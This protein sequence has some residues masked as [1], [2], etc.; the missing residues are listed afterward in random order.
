[1]KNLIFALLMLA[2]FTSCAKSQDSLFKDWSDVQ[3]FYT[4]G[5]LPPPYHYSYDVAVNRNGV[6]IL[7]YRL[8]YETNKDPLT[9]NFNVCA[10]DLK[11]LE[12]KIVSSNL[13]SGKIEAVPEGRH[14]I[15]G[16]LNKVRLI[17]TNPNPDLDQP[18]KMIESPYFPKD[19]YKE[20]LQELYDFI[21]KLVPEDVWTDV[22]TKKEEFEKSMK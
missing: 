10:D 4:A 1:M 2:V 11:L 21:K 20:N 14:P 5:P 16:S 6:S 15:G 17:C 22:K 9:Y 8:G 13:A 12:E 3:Y 19:E 18:P 7:T